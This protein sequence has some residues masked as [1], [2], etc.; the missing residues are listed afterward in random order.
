MTIY[1]VSLLGFS[2][3]AGQMVG[4]ILGK[5][6]GLDT[7][8]GGVG[9]AMLILI[10]LNSWF[11]KKKYITHTAEEGIQF[12]SNM[13]VPIIVA[14][15]ATQNVK[16]A[17]SGGLLALLVGITPMAI[18]FLCIPYISKLAKVPHQEHG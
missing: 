8:V 9:F 11:I 4:E 16:A 13:Y 10:L 17:V 6:I 14:M 12:W 1:G 5:A 3:L 2:F 15:S 7:N 18:C